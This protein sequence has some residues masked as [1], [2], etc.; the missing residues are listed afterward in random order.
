MATS[1]K[2]WLATGTLAATVAI[3]GVEG[4]DAV[5]T[6][7]AE[8][9]Q[10]FATAPVL[11]DS[12]ELKKIQGKEVAYREVGEKLKSFCTETADVYKGDGN[13]TAHVY[14]G[15]VFFVDVDGDSLAP[16]DLT[17]RSVDAPPE[18]NIVMETMDAAKEGVMG[19]FGMEEG[20][21]VEETVNG[22]AGATHD[23]YV[24]A[25]PYLATWF[26]ARDFDYTIFTPDASQSLA[27]RE[28]HDMT[29]MSVSTVPT[30]QGMKQTWVLTD[31]SAAKTLRWQVTSSAPLIHQG[32]GVVQCGQF[33]LPA[34]IAWD[35][36]STAVPVAVSVS[37][38]TLTYAVFDGGKRYPITVD[39]STAVNSTTSMTGFLGGRSS[40][41]SYLTARNNVDSHPNQ[42]IFGNGYAIRV[43]SSSSDPYRYVYRSIMRFDTSTLGTGIVISGATVRL[44]L[45]GGGINAYGFLVKVADGTSTTVADTTLY[46]NFDGWAASGVYSVTALADSFYMNSN[47]TLT[48]N[49][50]GLNQIKPTGITQMMLLDRWDIVSDPQGSYAMFNDATPVVLT[51]TY[52]Y[53]VNPPTGFTL[54]NAT[55]SSM[56]ATHTVNNSAAIDSMTLVDNVGVWKG[57]YA[58]TTATTITATGLSPGTR[59][60]FRAK[61]DSAGYSAYSNYDTLSTISNPPSWQF[62]ENPADSTKIL[63]GIGTNGNGTDTQYAIRDSTNQKWI[64]ADGSATTTKTWRTAAQW[65][66][67]AN[68]TGQNPAIKHRVGVT[69][70]NTDGVETAYAWGTLTLGNVRY[71]VIPADSAYGHSATH[72]VYDSARTAQLPA[73]IATSSTLKIG[74]QTGYTVSRVSLKFTLPRFTEILADTLQFT[75]AGDNSTTDFDLRVNVG[76]YEGD[77]AIPWENKSVNLRFI[78]WMGWLYLAPYHGGVSLTDRWNS[79]SYGATIKIPFNG[80]FLS[81]YSQFWPPQAV[82]LVVSSSRDSSRSTPSGNEYITVSEPKMLLRYVCPDSV[83][84]SIVVTAIAKDSLLVTWLDLATSETGFALVDAYTGA[85]LGGNDSTAANTSFKR[86][87]GLTPATVYRIKVQVLGGKIAGDISTVADSCATWAG[88]PKAP[89]VSMITNRVRKFV[90]DTTGTGN[91]AATKYAVQ[92]SISGKY[93]VPVFGGTDSMRAGSTD[94]TWVWQTYPQW[95]GSSGDSVR[96]PAGVRSGFRILSKNTP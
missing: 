49:A 21:T 24:K 5:T 47:K 36:D 7:P 19:L 3:G 42:T 71:A 29:G 93:V 26:A 6:T 35:A 9:E 53:Q 73:Q 57:K 87:G 27:F 16:L 51:V 30:A 40:N 32:E 77:S 96:F 37:G 25:G 85:R 76:N 48:L 80:Y 95:G 20:P 41:Y 90:V 89:T 75:G 62:K 43:G 28:L 39:P 74:Q 68:I 56:T 70:K 60:I 44:T 83:P 92:D 78:D 79:T 58:T 12:T 81:N 59:Y 23:S 4:Y 94:S 1:V 31:S 52:S 64:A 72:A 13:F 86:L 82:K 33:S 11:A 10:L 22:D 50:T 91:P 55:T 88:I 45:Y 69:A 84:S 38:D 8:Y 18:E 65:V 14:S 61:V 63:I 54:S 17:V 46:N 34:P 67:T 66:T 15:Q 2:N